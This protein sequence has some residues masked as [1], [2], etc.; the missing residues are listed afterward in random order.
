MSPFCDKCGTDDL[1]VKNGLCPECTEDK[2]MIVRYDKLYEVFGVHGLPDNSFFS[3]DTFLIGNGGDGM[4]LYQLTEVLGDDFIFA[5]VVDGTQADWKIAQNNEAFFE[6]QWLENNPVAEMYETV[7]IDGRFFD[8]REVEKLKLDD[9][10]KMIRFA[11][12]NN[13]ESNNASENLMDALMPVMKNVLSQCLG[14]WQT[15]SDGDTVFV[16]DVI[17]HL[18]SAYLHTKGDDEKWDLE[19][20]ISSYTE[21]EIIG[22]GKHREKFKRNEKIHFSIDDIKN[23]KQ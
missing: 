1:D 12:D 9:Q 11:V 7:L 19:N 15:A 20:A 14:D 2:K 13:H 8:K 22:H 16:T 5:V 3:V 10:I 23:G 21:I 17:A 4:Q 6:S 18:C